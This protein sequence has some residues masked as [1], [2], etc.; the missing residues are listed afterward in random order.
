LAMNIIPIL[1]QSDSRNWKYWKLKMV[2][3]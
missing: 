2:I 3:L 1:K